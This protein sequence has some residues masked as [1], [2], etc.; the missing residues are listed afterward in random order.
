MINFQPNS[1]HVS[2]PIAFQIWKKPSHLPLL[3]TQMEYPNHHLQIDF[4]CLYVYKLR[5]RQNPTRTW[6][7][8][9]ILSIA[10]LSSVHHG[11][12]IFNYRLLCR[13]MLCAT[14]P[15]RMSM[16]SWSRSRSGNGSWSIMSPHPNCYI[17]FYKM[18]F[19]R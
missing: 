1:I 3:S 11:K 6:I 12:P 16:M 9:S 18:V 17:L 19:I 8:V 13:Y 7:A 5:T 4:L 2:K 10:P 14:P 15:M